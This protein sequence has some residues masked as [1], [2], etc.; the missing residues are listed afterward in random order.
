MAS[1]S[2]KSNVVRTSISSSATGTGE[3]RVWACFLDL[4][5]CLMRTPRV[6]RLESKRRAGSLTPDELF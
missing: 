4:M 2:G 1:P 3:G 5:R 6:P